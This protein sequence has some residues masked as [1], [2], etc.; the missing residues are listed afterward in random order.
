MF[1]YIANKRAYEEL[2]AGK[3]GGKLVLLDIQIVEGLERR[4]GALELHGR[5]RWDE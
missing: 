3:Q 4:G 5:G 2:E 1:L